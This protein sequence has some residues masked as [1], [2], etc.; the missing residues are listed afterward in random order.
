M[1]AA[2]DGKSVLHCRTESQVEIVA[3]KQ[4]CYI[5][6]YDACNAPDT[7][8]KNSAAQP[9]KRSSEEFQS[10]FCRSR[11]QTLTHRLKLQ[12][13]YL[14]GTHEEIGLR[15]ALADPSKRAR[16][17]AAAPIAVAGLINR[18]SNA[19]RWVR[20]GGILIPSLSN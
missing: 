19:R 4:A 16:M 6:T 20:R 5:S 12:L 2:R 14:S 15:L 1:E 11:I 17:K 9:L 18:K 3:S 8:S 13:P 10:Q 7:L